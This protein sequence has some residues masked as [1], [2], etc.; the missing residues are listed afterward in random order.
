MKLV[1]EAHLAAA[2]ACALAIAQA[3]AI[4]PIDQYPPA[5]GRFQEAGDVEE[6]GLA[7]ARRTHQG[8]CLAGMQFGGGASQYRNLP[9]TLPK[10]APHLLQLEYRA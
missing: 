9:I 3:G 7:G 4:H 1:N 5:I 2:H 10:G 6:R 8:D